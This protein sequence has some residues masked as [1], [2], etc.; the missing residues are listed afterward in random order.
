MTLMMNNN[1]NKKSFHRM[2][3]VKA[4]MGETTDDTYQSKH[5]NKE[6]TSVFH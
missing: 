6:K 5:N 3:L 1:N 4:K 2:T